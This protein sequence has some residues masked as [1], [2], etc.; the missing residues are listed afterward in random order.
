MLENDGPNGKHSLKPIIYFHTWR[1]GH[2]LHSFYFS[3]FYPTHFC[4]FTLMFTLTLQLQA[5][6]FSFL[7]I[8]LTSFPSDMLLR[9]VA[10]L[11]FFFAIISTNFPT[12]NAVSCT[13]QPTFISV[14]STTEF[15]FI[16]LF[17]SSSF[18][19]ASCSLGIYSIRLQH[20]IC[21]LCVEQ[22]GDC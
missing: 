6:Y 1:V 4:L 2:F 11:F 12:M 7:G 20:C 13:Y 14:I 8:A 9:S 16:F 21:L 18:A 10:R 5:L 15:Y 22:K 19:V 17:C 3:Y